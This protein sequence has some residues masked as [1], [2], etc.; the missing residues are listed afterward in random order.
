MEWT[1]MSS[2]SLAGTLTR[3][4][5]KMMTPTPRTMWQRVWRAV[6]AVVLCVSVMAAGCAG[7]ETKPDEEPTE[8]SKQGDSAGQTEGGGKTAE[9]GGAD[10]S[11]SVEST[12]KT[13]ETSNKSSGGGLFSGGA[14]L[15][16]VVDKADPKRPD[17]T[18]RAFEKLTGDDNGHIA[19]Y[20]IGVMYEIKGET[21]RA[22]E[23][24][25]K[26]LSSEPDFTPALHN[27]AMIHLRS[28]NVSEASSVTQSYIDKRPDNIDHR[29]V[30]LEI[31]L[32]KGQYQDTIRRSKALLRRDE[33][34]V[35]AM[36]AL[37]RANFRMER[38]ELAKAVLTR[39]VDINPDRA[40]A[41]YLFGLIAMQ[42]DD[43]AKAR[44]NF[45]KAI[46]LQPRFAAAR[47]NLGLLYHEATDYDA[48]KEQF[49]KATDYLPSFKEAYLNLGNAYKGMGKFDEA[50]SSF[51]R[52]IELDGNYADAYFNLGILYMDSKIGDLDKIP[53]LQ[54][55]IEYLNEYKGVVK[56]IESDD[57]VNDYISEARE[58][59]KVERQRQEMMRQTQ[60]SSSGGSGSSTDSQNGSS[61]SSDSNGDGGNG[62]SN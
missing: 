48:A 31:M 50:K 19:Q 6:C 1:A 57:P 47:N 54:K 12:D 27:T 37:A 21:T 16:S 52:A 38:H 45:E 5:T 4:D 36:L 35:R 7:G 26:A 34:N 46:E 49:Q 51:D 32:H 14:D 13:S 24:Y 18:I 61:D 25:Q 58:K 20:N 15:S 55:A 3:G 23:A 10:E 56:R 39:A 44:A 53:R 9:E 22:I 42:N 2:E 41:Y 33:R 40:D 11:G 43:D 29:T 17:E 62:G 60:K 30:Q 59:I 28:G 8:S